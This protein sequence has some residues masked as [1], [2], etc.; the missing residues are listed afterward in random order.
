[1][2]YSTGFSTLVAACAARGEVTVTARE[3]ARSIEVHRVILVEG[4][5]DRAALEA[6]AARYGRRL[7]A[8]GIFIVPMGGA[9]SI[10]RFLRLLGPDGFDVRVAGLCDA[11]EDGFFRR[12]LEAA[13]LGSVLARHHMSELGFFV[14]HPDLEGELIRALGSAAAERVIDDEGDL[15]A[16]RTFQRQPHQRQQSLEQQLHRFVGT[17]SGRKERYARAFAN[18]VDL[19]AVPTPIHL[20]L[21]VV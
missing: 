5:S 10:G 16:F 9:T 15:K 7:E 20:L 3:F 18:N 2:S 14:C 1:V 4:V 8:E 19:T 12:S 21:T 17:L 11:G 6:L 13:G